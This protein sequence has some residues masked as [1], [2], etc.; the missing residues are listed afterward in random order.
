METNKLLA[1]SEFA[2]TKMANEFSRT[3]DHSLTLQ[4]ATL[5]VKS[6]SHHYV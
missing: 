3:I 5:G 1:L 4:N 2:M 6:T